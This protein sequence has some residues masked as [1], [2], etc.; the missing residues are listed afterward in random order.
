[1]QP[2]HSLHHQSRRLLWS[3]MEITGGYREI[4]LGQLYREGSK[5]LANRN[6]GESF[7]D[8][9]ARAILLRCCR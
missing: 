9:P 1:M 8:P 3:V 2:D 5:F 7:F 4:T 6:E